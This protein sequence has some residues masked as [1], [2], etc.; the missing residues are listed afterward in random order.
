MHVTADADQK[1]NLRGALHASH[2]FIPS[3]LIS[4]CSLVA[5]AL[6]PV[7]FSVA[8]SLRSGAV[9]LDALLRCAFQESLLLVVGDIQLLF[10]ITEQKILHLSRD[11][12]LDILR[13]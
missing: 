9:L 10:L 12:L 6:R 7:F 13:R 5:V 2:L 4:I 1:K 3:L 8:V 11:L